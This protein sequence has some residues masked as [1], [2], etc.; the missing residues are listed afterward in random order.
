MALRSAR[1]FSVFGFGDHPWT[2]VESCLKTFTEGGCVELSECTQF[3]N[4]LYIEDAVKALTALVLC[5]KML[6]D[7]GSCY[8]IAAGKEETRPLRWFVEKMYELS[9]Q[10]GSFRYGTRASN[11][12]GPI[13]LM[14]DISK[15]TQVTGWKPEIDF[16]EGVRRELSAIMKKE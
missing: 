12:E 13:H 2:L 16:E 8:N 4:F 5:D 11:A 14:P 10:K 6:A 3:W 15:I 1:I 9:P 7:C